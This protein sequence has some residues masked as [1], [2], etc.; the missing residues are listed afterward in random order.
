MKKKLIRVTGRATPPA[1]H[2]HFLRILREDWGEFKAACRLKV[3]E[4]IKNFDI[5]EFTSR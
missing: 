3:E 4:S 2:L 1:H 5:M